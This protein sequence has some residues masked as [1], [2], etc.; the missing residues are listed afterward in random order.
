MTES[1]ATAELFANMQVS[2]GAEP[3]PKRTVLGRESIPNPFVQAVH[4]SYADAINPA[5][6]ENGATCQIF[7][8]V[9]AKGMTFKD[10]K[11]K[12]KNGKTVSTGQWQQ[13]PNV[14]T[15]LYLLRQAAIKNECGVRIVVDYK[16]GENGQHLLDVKKGV[17]RIR[18]VGTKKKDRKNKETPD[19]QQAQ[20]AA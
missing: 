8:P 4:D 2:R 18:F 10:T 13:H 14:T 9:D 12:D 19:T 17:V 16:D 7:A 3:L 15:A 5:I 1:T 20:S 11:R 6:G